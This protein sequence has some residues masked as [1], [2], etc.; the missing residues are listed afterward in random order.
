[1]SGLKRRLETLEGRER[2]PAPSAARGRMVGHLG[3][4]AELRRGG[5][6]PEEAAQVEAESAAVGR[7]LLE[8]RGGRPWEA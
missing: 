7:R 4:V 2:P 1:M 3:R 6:C 5:L 8:I